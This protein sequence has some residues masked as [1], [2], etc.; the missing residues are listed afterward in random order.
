MRRGARA[1]RR[2]A[3]TSRATAFAQRPAADGASVVVGLRPEHFSLGEANG[4]DRRR[5][6]RPAG[7]LQRE[8]RRR[9]H[10]VPRRRRRAAGGADRPIAASA[11]ADG[12]S[13][14][15]ELSEGQAQRL[16]RRHR[17][18]NVR[19]ARP[20]TKGGRCCARNTARRRPGARA[21][22]PCRRGERR[23]P[24][25]VPHVVERERDGGAQRHRRSVRG[26][27]QHDHRRVGAAR[28]G[29]REPAGQPVRR[30]HAA[31]PLHRR[32]RRASSATSRRR[33][34]ARTSGR[35]STRSAPPRTS[36]RRCCEAITIDGE[37]LKI[38]T[39]VHID[40]MVYYNKK[41][42]EA[43][44]VDPTKWTSLDDMFADQKKVKDAGYTFIAIGG[45][46]FQAGYTF[47]AAARRGRRAGDLQPL[48]RRHA[49]RRPCFDEPGLREAI[50][51][52]RKITGADR[53]GLGQ[54]RLE[55][56]HQHRD[57]RQGADADPRRLDEGP[58]AR[59]QQGARRGLRLH[60]HP[61]HQ[62]AV[63][64][65]RFASASSAASTRRR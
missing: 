59:Q 53:R 39:A 54:P 14:Q 55:R 17:A 58:V 38:P 46:T 29:R 7:P 62:G 10:R 6:L 27:G 32:R 25:A 37:V 19:P 1:D 23:R 24:D 15:G 2:R 45:N 56:H 18:A 28:D 34:R 60:Q 57:R 64:D 11:L 50:E 20:D 52:F 4:S 8:D 47:H 30:R 41:V 3:W 16:R 36:R 22:A 63:G 5:G 49:G 9:R 35:S 48:L 33:G 44:G 43:A 26:E 40:G 12:R 61:R 42:A 31:Q 65:G 51:A 13:R 21:S